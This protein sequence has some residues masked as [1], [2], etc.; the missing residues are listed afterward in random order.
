MGLELIMKPVKTWAFKDTVYEIEYLDGIAVS[1]DMKQV[2]ASELDKYRWEGQQGE[3]KFALSRPMIWVESNATYYYRD[4]IIVSL[5]L[6]RMISNTSDMSDWK[7]V[8][9][10][11]IHPFL[12]KS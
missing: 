6:H 2:T 10:P 4:L 1:K 12:I 8:V 9:S 3:G 5:N 7:L 11:P